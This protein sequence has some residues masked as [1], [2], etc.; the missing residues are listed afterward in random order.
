MKVLYLVMLILRFLRCSS[1]GVV[2][3]ISEKCG[4][5]S[6][7]NQTSLYRL[8]K[9]NLANNK[10]NLTRR[11]FLTFPKC[12]VVDLR[13]VEIN[14]TSGA[15]NLLSIFD[16]RNVTENELTV[17]RGGVFSPNKELGVSFCERILAK[18]DLSRE[19]AACHPLRRQIKKYFSF[20]LFST[21]ITS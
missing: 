11:S 12:F 7:P 1:F 5:R 14:A 4:V 17:A 19:S 6:D 15:W 2:V 16:L 20:K 13:G 3:S 8:F 18:T 10:L 21:T 9:A